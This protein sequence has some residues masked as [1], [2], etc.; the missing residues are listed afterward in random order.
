MT[1]TE[2]RNYN[3]Y[4]MTYEIMKLSRTGR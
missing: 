3:L 1:H 4:T 2:H